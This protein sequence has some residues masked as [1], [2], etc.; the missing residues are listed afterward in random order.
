MSLFSTTIDFL[1]D[2]PQIGMFSGFGSGA[3]L[4]IQIFITDESLLKL[5]AACG[6]WLGALVALVTL[7]IKSIELFNKALIYIKSRRK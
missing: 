7:I 6:V 4:S 5:V 1:A 3:I 2:K